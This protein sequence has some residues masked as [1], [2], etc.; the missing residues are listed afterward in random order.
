M[1]ML[2][3]KTVHCE[4]KNKNCTETISFGEE[5]ET[6]FC[7]EWAEL[8]VFKASYKKSLVIHNVNTSTAKE[9]VQYCSTIF[10]DNKCFAC[11]RVMRALLMEIENDV[12][13]GKEK[14]YMF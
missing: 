12:F 3:E 1:F 14:N 9:L 7:R 2:K 13:K 4:I 11:R 6:K 5:Q 8:L 10:I